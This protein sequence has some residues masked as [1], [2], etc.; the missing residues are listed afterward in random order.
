MK[1]VK[2]TERG[3]KTMAKGSIPAKVSVHPHTHKALKAI[4]TKSGFKNIGGQGTGN[5][6]MGVDTRY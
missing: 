6:L 3:Q 2:R 4:E 1:D 5:G